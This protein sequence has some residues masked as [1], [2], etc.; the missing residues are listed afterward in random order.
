MSYFPYGE[1]RTSTPDGTEKFGTYYR[2]GVGQD[3]AEQR[4]YNNGTGRFWSVDPG[5][6]ATANPS[7][8]TSL[9]RYAYVNGDPVNHRDPRGLYQVIVG[10]GMC[11][12]GNGEYQEWVECDYS[13]GGFFS[14]T[15]PGE[16]PGGGGGGGPGKFAN[17]ESVGSETQLAFVASHYA[18]AGSEAATIQSEMPYLANGTQ[19][20]ANQGNVT[21]AFLDWS[22]WESG[23]GQSNFA[24]SKYNYFGYGN[25]TF[26]SSMSWGAELAY[27]LATVPNTPTN[28]NPGQAPYS[29]F[30]VEALINNPNAS[31]ASILQAIANAGYNSV[32]PN[33]GNTIAGP[34]GVNVQPMIDCLK[35][36]YASSM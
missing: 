30:L 29:S 35:S 11:I 2:D 33:Y 19:V 9:N 34:N 10:E 27:I 26:S 16:D 15:D 22:S 21:A 3:Y 20:Q 24:T 14:P 31:P 17:C 12:V 36:N 25:V 18:A 5:G 23:W 32:D 6:V 28:P 7:N 1:E 4:Y 8:P 13:E